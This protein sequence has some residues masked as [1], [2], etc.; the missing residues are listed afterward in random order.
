[1]EG[2]LVFQQIAKFADQKT[3]LNKYRYLLVHKAN[4]IYTC[5]PLTFRTS[6][7]VLLSGKRS[8]LG[9]STV[10]LLLVRL[11]T[12][13]HGTNRNQSGLQALEKLQ[14]QISGSGWF[15]MF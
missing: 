13:R 10:D 12:F 3:K 5:A 14:Y 1:M 2:F 9:T 15:P 6:P 7:R 4:L 11:D 8:C